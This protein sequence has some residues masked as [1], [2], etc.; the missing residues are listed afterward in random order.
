MHKRSGQG[1]SKNAMIYVLYMYHIVKR[2]IRAN[3]MK[4]DKKI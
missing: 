2:R 4:M 1:F 3:K